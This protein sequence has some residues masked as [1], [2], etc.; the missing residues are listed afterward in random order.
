MLKRRGLGEKIILASWRE[1]IS[2]RAADHKVH[3][4]IKLAK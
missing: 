3:F 4:E 2:R 1:I